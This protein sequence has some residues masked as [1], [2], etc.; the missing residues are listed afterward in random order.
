MQEGFLQRVCYSMKPDEASDVLQADT[1]ALKLNAWKQLASEEGKKIPEDGVLHRQVLYAGA[2]HVLHKV[3]LW[4]KAETELDGLKSRFSQ[5][6]YENLLKLTK[7]MEGLKEWMDAV[8]TAG[9][10]CVVVSCLD[11]ETWLKL[12][13][14]WGSRSIFR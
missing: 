10:P 9:I 7:P 6:Y 12:W 13:S 3:F 14:G 1:R 11:E 8:S 5:L 4:E 2:D